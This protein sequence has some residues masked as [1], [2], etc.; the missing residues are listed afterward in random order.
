MMSSGKTASG[1]V[2][3][4]GLYVKVTEQCGTDMDGQAVVDQIGGQEPPKVVGSEPDI[5]E[6]RMGG[7]ERLDCL[8]DDL[9]GSPSTHRAAAV[10]DDVLEQER[11]RTR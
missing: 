5:R 3:A 6:L 2:A 4:C 7:D 9:T 11:H 1:D 10:A 8:A